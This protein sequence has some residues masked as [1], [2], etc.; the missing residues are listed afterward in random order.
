MPLNISD[1]CAENVLHFKRTNKQSK[2]ADLRIVKKR[3][4][5]DISLIIM[6]ENVSKK[7]RCQ[8][9]V[10]LSFFFKYTGGA[11]AALQLPVDAAMEEM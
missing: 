6:L 4:K 2:Y 10:F 7:K 3:L 9:N 1:V 8:K 5:I 11:S